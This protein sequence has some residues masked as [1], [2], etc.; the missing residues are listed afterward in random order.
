MT[1]LRT[2]RFWL[3]IGVSVLCLWLAVRHL[4]WAEFWS[5]VRQA[6]YTWL[7]PAMLFQVWS[8]VARAQRW[9]VLLG[10]EARLIDAFWAQGIGYLLT[11]AP[12]S[13]RRQ[14]AGQGQSRGVSY[15]P[16]SR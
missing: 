14:W 9:V 10:Q 6:H 13:H 11:N 16:G 3:G 2:A 8:V 7:V 1:T 5:A 15:S 4:P 12:I